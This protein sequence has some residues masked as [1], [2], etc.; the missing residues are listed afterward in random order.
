MRLYS[1]FFV[2]SEIFY[3]VKNKRTF[4]YVLR[5]KEDIVQMPEAIPYRTEMGAAV[6]TVTAEVNRNFL[7]TGIRSGKA[8][9]HFRC[10]FHTGTMQV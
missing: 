2:V 9:D 3:I 1:N 6:P 4:L 7:D 10:K 5:S 8:G